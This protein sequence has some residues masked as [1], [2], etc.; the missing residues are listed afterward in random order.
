MIRTANIREDFLITLQLVSDLSYA[1]LIIDS[2]TEHMQ[3][4][5]RK[6]PSLVGR[7]RATFLKL[8]SALDLPLMRINQARSAD[9]VSVSQYYSTELVSYIRHVLHVIPQ[10]MFALVEQIIHLQTNVIKEMPMRLDKDK[11]KDFA[12]LDHRFQVAK[13]TESVS[14]FT[15]GIL[16]MKT[17]LVGVVRLDP[18]RLLEEGIRRELV[19]RTANAMHGTL[20]FNPKAKS[21]ELATKL[22]LLGETMTGLRKSFEYIQDYVRIQ[23]LRMFQEETARIVGYNVEQEC[24]T[25]QIGYHV[26]DWQS[27]FQSTAVPIPRLQS[28]PKSSATTFVGRLA[29]EILRITDPKSTVFVSFTNTW[30]DAKSQN[31]VMTLLLFSQLE[32]AISTSGLAGLDTLFAFMIATEISVSIANVFY[33]YFPSK[34]SE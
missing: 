25:F 32:R 31:E 7:L 11:L 12:Q 17:T 26:Q 16:A 9:L 10:S 23:G 34:D 22:A 24:N 20:F 13:L 3:I 8:S 14:T 6:D 4:A 33:Y 29:R 27:R 2:Y 18:K 21:S 5:V 15:E 30:Y 1:W 19:V 28:D